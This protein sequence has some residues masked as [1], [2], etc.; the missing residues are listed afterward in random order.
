MSVQLQN[1]PLCSC[2]VQ[3]QLQKEGQGGLLHCPSGTE[4][5]GVCVHLVS[6]PFQVVSQ[7]SMLLLFGK[8]F[9]FMVGVRAVAHLHQVDGKGALGG[10]DMGGATGDEED[11]RA[12]LLP[13][14]LRDGGGSQPV[15]EGFVRHILG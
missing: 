9:N 2:P 13:T 4:G 10:R 6:S 7:L 12:V 1:K 14:P 8:E 11:I 15:G 3:S 5:D